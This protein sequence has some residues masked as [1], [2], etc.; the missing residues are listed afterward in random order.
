MSQTVIES[1]AIETNG[2]TLR[3][4]ADAPL[5]LDSGA[6]LAP[7]EIAYKT[8]GR[9]NAERSNAVLVCHALT[10]DQHAASVHPITGK[11][12]WWNRVIGPGLPLDPDRYFIICTNVVGGCMGSTGPSSIDPA[13]GKPFGLTFPVITIADMVRAQA[14][15]LDALGIETLFAAVG[16]SMG[17]M[18]VLQ[19]AAD[20]PHRLHSAVCIAAAARHSAQNIAFHEVGRQAI[21]ADPDWRGGAYEAHG[22]RP[23]KGL[24]VARMAAHITYLSEAAL[25]RK[26]G[27]ELQ[28]D[29]LS[30]GFDAPDFQVE[31][32][33]RY[34]GASFV[35]RFDA[36]SY[37]Y[38]TRALDYFDLAASHGGVLANAFRR[39]RDVRFCVLSFS[40]DWLY[41]TGES[42]DIVRALNAAGCRAS[43]VEIETDKGHDAIFLE[44]PVLHSALR[45]FF[46]SQ[47]SRRG[48]A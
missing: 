40:S 12:G 35:D 46:E 47:A 2:G 28:R 41:S 48:L 31:S 42:R 16:G 29:G 44:E 33:L 11:P 20:Y 23:E 27:R 13:T 5:R 14:M 30:W 4:P 19:W 39:A 15:L 18:Q 17:G 45:G 3:L 43:F 7:L 24:A 22:V 38:I 9:L 21:M 8:Y 25:Q 34:Q 6:T 37:L 36:N 26:F 10:G 1:P 32:Y